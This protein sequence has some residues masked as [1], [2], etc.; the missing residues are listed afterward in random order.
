LEI[1]AV[2]NNDGLRKELHGKLKTLTLEMTCIFL[3]ALLLGFW[4]LIEWL[5]DKYVIKPLVLTGISTWMLN[6]FQIVFSASTFTVVILYIIVDIATIIV[7]SWRK[8]KSEIFQ[9]P[10]QEGDLG[11]GDRK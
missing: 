8:V 3:D 5:L 4:V 11:I 7:K 10:T 9:I 2:E 1:L 6:V